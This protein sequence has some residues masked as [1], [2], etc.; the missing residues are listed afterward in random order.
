MPTDGKG[1]DEGRNSESGRTEMR[2]FGRTQ[3]AHAPVWGWTSPSVLAMPWRIQD[4]LTPLHRRPQVEWLKKESLL[5]GLQCLWWW[6]LFQQ[7]VNPCG[8]EA[9]NRGS[10]DPPGNLLYAYYQSLLLY[11]LPKV[12]AC[13]RTNSIKFLAQLENF[14]LYQG[15][16]PQN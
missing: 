11:A 2:D 9:R 5:L 10:W 14:H 6:L 4:R 3:C 16:R 12:S 7:P 8:A 1:H 15:T 13:Q